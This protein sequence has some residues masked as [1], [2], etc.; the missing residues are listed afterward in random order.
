M[1]R[2]PQKLA[3][4]NRFRIG[5]SFGLRGWFAVLYER[6]P[7]G[8]FIDPIQS[9]IGSFPD[10]EGARREAEEW[11]IAEGIPTDFLGNEN[12]Q[13]E[14]NMSDKPN[15]IPFS[16]LL[17]KDE[18]SKG[19][20]V[21][22][23]KGTIKKLFSNIRKGGDGD[24][25]YEYQDGI[26]VDGEGKEIKITFSKCTQPSSAVGK[27]VYIR[28]ISTE[29]GTKGITLEEYE[30]KRSIKITP[31]A[32]IEYSGGGGGG[33]AAGTGGSSS[34]QSQHSP[35]MAKSNV[36]PKEALKDMIDCHAAVALLVNEKYQDAP[37]AFKQG[38][39]NTIFI[40]C[41]KAGLVA[42]F[43][44]RYAKK[45]YPPPPKDPAQWKECVMSS[46]QYE[47]KTLA[48]IPDADLL[49][50][51]EYYDKKEDNSPLA[52]CI[53]QAARDRNILPKPEPEPGQDPDLD[54]PPEDDI[55]F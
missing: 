36:H 42:D 32:E 44:K 38:S 6:S 5:I 29:N 15:P 27:S 41:C 52:E 8:G 30:G 11:S 50:Y 20:V 22:A 21:R 4:E 37:D 54:P 19:D 2:R 47:G 49:K 25:T 51:F 55:P 17:N 48:E 53:Y 7:D 33:G 13:E 43:A 18:F 35:G 31:S 12:Q 3:Q 39:V 45:V 24:R 16:R 46:G 23:V 34:A 1:P 28:A 14:T 10:P 9:G 26:L 40:E